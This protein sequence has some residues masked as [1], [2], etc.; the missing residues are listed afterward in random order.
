[1]LHVMVGLLG[2]MLAAWSPIFPYLTRPKLGKSSYPEGIILHTS[3]WERRPYIHCCLHILLRLIS[4]NYNNR[5]GD[6]PTAGLNVSPHCDLVTRYYTIACCLTAPNYYLTNVNL[7]AVRSRD[8]DLRVIPHWVVVILVIPPILILNAN[9][10]KSRLSMTSFSG[11]KSFWN[12]QSTKLWAKEFSR[13]YNSTLI[14][15]GHIP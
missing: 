11:A 7:S 9:L 1:M 5:P 14:S 6:C 3:I 15:N 10:S 13:R 4:W 2:C 12:K 8:T